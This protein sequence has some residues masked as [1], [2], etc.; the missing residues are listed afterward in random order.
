MHQAA[1]MV[2]TIESDLGKKINVPEEVAWRMGYISNEQL[3]N[4]ADRYPK[5]GYGQY[6]H[7]LLA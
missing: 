7:K 3:M 1:K 4:Q 6:L 5:S 2:F